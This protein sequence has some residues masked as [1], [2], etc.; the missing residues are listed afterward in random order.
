MS[1][2]LRK[3]LVILPVYN[4]AD[5]ALALI[6]ALKERVTLPY[7]LAVIDNGCAERLSFAQARLEQNIGMGGA[8]WYAIDWF[9]G[10][11]YDYYWILSTSLSFQPGQTDPLQELLEVFQVDPACVG[12]GA[13]WA[14]RTACWPHRYHAVVASQPQPMIDLAALWDRRWFE[15]VG[16]FDRRLKSGWGSDFELAAKARWGEKRLWICKPA[17]MRISEGATYAN[18]QSGDR[19][20]YQAQARLEMVN[21]FERKYGPAWANLLIGWFTHERP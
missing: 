2:A 4:R 21:V 11:E 10:P 7:D 1:K 14:G 17:E 13:A 18:G 5:R 20:A 16:G 12:V 3:T 9:G 15:R 6:D 19:Q 8:V